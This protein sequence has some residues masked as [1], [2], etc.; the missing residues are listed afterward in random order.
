MA[1]LA[2]SLAIDRAERMYAFFSGL[3]LAT[4]DHDP[5]YQIISELEEAA[6][7]L[8]EQLQFFLSETKRGK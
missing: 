7:L 6:R 3:A 1:D 4:E 2:T 8:I 5:R